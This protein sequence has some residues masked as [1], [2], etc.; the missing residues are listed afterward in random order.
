VQNAA[1]IGGRTFEL[2]LNTRVFRSSNF[3]YN[4]TL[5]GE[6][7]RQKIDQLGR[8][9][10][11]VGSGAQGQ[12]IFLLTKQGETMGVIYGQK[13]I[14]S[15][16]Q[17]KDN[18]LNANIDLNNYVVNDEGLVVLKSCINLV[19]ERPIAY[20]DKNGKN[21]VKI[22]NV[23]PNL[24]IR[25]REYC[26]CGWPSPSTVYSTARSGATSTTSRRT[27]CPGYASRCR[28]TRLESPRRPSI[29][30]ILHSR[31]YNGL[32]PSSL[33]RGGWLICKLREMSVSYNFATEL[34]PALP[35][36]AH[37]SELEGRRSFDAT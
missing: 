7:Y 30:S 23:N 3:S 28:S 1:R 6:R 16:D 37:R 4:F 34:R 19:C 27:G 32:E 26:S 24:H 14:T 25:L 8:A 35:F 33:L 29:R 2:Q 10:V 36:H 15:L 21:N 20:V 11:R 31:L 17:L 22:G 12:A 13:W 5:T 18:P 9:S